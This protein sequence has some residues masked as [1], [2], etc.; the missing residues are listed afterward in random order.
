[1]VTGTPILNRPIE[2]YPILKVLSPATIDPYNDFYKFGR[3]YC[4]A[5]MD[6]FSFNVNGASHTEELNQRLKSNYM[7][8]R[9]TSEVA[10]QLPSKRYQMIFL[11]MNKD[12][13]IKMDVIENAVKRDFS[14]QRLGTG[15]GEL[16]TLRR[17]T[18]EKKLDAAMEYII[19]CVEQNEKLVIFAYHHSVIKR[20]EKE[21]EKYGT[22]ILDGTKTSIQRQKVLHNFIQ[23]KNDKVFIGQ[24]QAA[25][26]GIDGLQQV[27]SNVLFIEW[28]WV[29][30]EIEQACKRVHRIGQTKPVLIQFLVWENS[31][32][33]HMMRVALE[34]V[35]VIRKVMK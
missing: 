23:G 4:N 5:F 3:R 16:A 8:R 17:E 15:G 14:Y 24:I 12:T 29:P 7:I 11:S 21:L 32:E 27:C 6:G 2:L 25:G 26:Q 28:S 10:P 9:T 22:T 13:Q 30:G 18:A 33:E 34:K 19:N 35:E 31:I 20:L 1:M